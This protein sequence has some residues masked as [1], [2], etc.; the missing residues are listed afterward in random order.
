[1]PQRIGHDDVAADA[2]GRIGA[3]A[4][5]RQLL[6][7][8][9]DVAAHVVAFAIGFLDV[10]GDERHEG[11]SGL[12]DHEL[13]DAL[14]IVQV[15]VAAPIREGIP[16]RVHVDGASIEIYRVQMV[17]AHLELG[18]AHRYLAVDIDV[19]QVA[20]PPL[21]AVFRARNNG[22]EPDGHRIVRATQIAHDDQ[23]LRPMADLTVAVRRPPTAVLELDDGVVLDSQ[24]SI[25]EG[26]ACC[27]GA[28]HHPDYVDIGV[29]GESRSRVRRMAESGLDRAEPRDVAARRIVDAK[30]GV[31]GDRR[32]A[33]GGCRL[34]GGDSRG[35]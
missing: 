34:R 21:R 23:S 5:D 10:V 3:A 6:V 30:P 27:G 22:V 15:E 18:A 35:C 29:V 4:H 32:T 20:I 19:V 11:R 14:R 17:G 24:R 8:A 31:G 2:D 9:E 1:M 16:I 28:V 33:L 13:R 26:V 25:V 12:S 7:V